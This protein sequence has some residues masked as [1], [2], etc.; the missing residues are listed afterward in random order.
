[1][2]F[3]EVF[4]FQKVKQPPVYVTDTW[5][6]GGVGRLV[7]SG[8]ALSST[9]HGTLLVSPNGYTYRQLRAEASLRIPVSLPSS[10]LAGV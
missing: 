9:F 7:S 10:E 4:G 8:A 5:L 6:C 3:A 1:M 2:A